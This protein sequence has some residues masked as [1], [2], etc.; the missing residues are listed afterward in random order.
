[1]SKGTCQRGAGALKITP[2]VTVNP[3]SAGSGSVI[4]M[5]IK[6]SNESLTNTPENIPLP[7]LKL[8]DN[9]TGDSEKR[10]TH[11]LPRSRTYF[12]F[13]PISG[14]KLVFPHGGMCCM[15]AHP[16]PEGHF[17][18]SLF[19]L[20]HCYIY[21]LLVLCLALRNLA[22]CQAPVWLLASALDTRDRVRTHMTFVPE[23]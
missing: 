23:A 15:P 11:R 18:A 12:Y 3:E 4:S 22:L 13:R 21:L 17:G 8:S 16:D 19:Y 2:R 6:T 5:N 20:I 1:M 10:P 7:A 9:R 14:V